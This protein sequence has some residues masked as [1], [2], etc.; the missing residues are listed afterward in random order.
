MELKGAHY[1]RR[2][3][4]QDWAEWSAALVSSSLVAPKAVAA[5]ID[6]F[7]RAIDPFLTAVADRNSV[8]DPLTEEEFARASQGP[9]KAQ[10]ALVNAIR[11]SMGKD[12]GELQ[13]WIGGS[14]TRPENWP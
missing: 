8:K 7:A 9:A 10:R 13:V 5:A 4:D 14:L 11:R 6:N 1:D 2:P 12:L 3:K